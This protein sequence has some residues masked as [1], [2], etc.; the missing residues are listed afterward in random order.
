[1]SKGWIALYRKLQD[2]PIWTAEPFTRGQAWVDLLLLA[3]HSEGYFYKRGVKVDLGIG[4]L[5]RSEVE[6][7]DRWSWSRNKVRKFLKDLESE[8]QIEQQKNSVTT[9]ITLKNYK[10][11][12]DKNSNLNSKKTTEG[13]TEG[14]QKVQQKDTYNNVNNTNNVNNLNNEGENSPTP[15]DSFS[16]EWPTGGVTIPEV[17]RS[18]DFIDAFLL[19]ENHLI[20]K[21]KDVLSPQQIELQFLELI[22]LKKQGNDPVDVI[23]QTVRNGNKS[24]YALREDFNKKPQNE[25]TTRNTKKN[26]RTHESILD[27]IN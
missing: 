7:A 21:F 14:Q 17:L 23:R 11:H 20:S 15:D 25:S 12:Q 22:N 4:Q 3:N 1:M 8:Q 2:N 18:K 16:D 19:Y 26:K 10:N 13:T 6:L 27:R 24:F 5:G 9:V